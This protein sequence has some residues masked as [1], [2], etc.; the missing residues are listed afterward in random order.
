MATVVS[1][2]LIN[3]KPLYFHQMKGFNP[4]MNASESV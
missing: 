1:A 4:G 2:R 3:E